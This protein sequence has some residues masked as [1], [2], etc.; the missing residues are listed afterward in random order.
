MDF[1]EKAFTDFMGPQT[2]IDIMREIA[3]KP[4]KQLVELVRYNALYA[5]MEKYPHLLE[6]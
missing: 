6:Y 4:F 2:N 5:D 3:S 1:S